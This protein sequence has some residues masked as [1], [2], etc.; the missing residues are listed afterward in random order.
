M[1]AKIIV[2]AL[3][4]ICVGGI[5]ATIA[6]IGKHRGPVTP[7]LAARVTFLQGLNIVGLVY[8]YSEL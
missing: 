6:V 7:G 8:V 3:V 4:G 2:A 1:I 5:F